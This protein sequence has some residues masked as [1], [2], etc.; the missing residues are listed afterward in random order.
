MNADPHATA[1]EP[2][3]AADPED[4][5]FML[6]ESHWEALQR[7]EL[8][9]LNDWVSQHP[10]ERDKLPHL[11]LVRRLHAALQVLREDSTLEEQA[12]PPQSDQAGSA[13][14]QFLEPGTLIDQCRI[15]SLLGYGGMGEVYLAEHTVMGNKIAV[16]VLP[17]RRVGDTEAVGRFQQEI[18]NQARMSPHPNVA[19]ALH[20]SE[21]QG[22]CY[23]VMEY[24]PGIDLHEYVRRQGPLPWRQA[25]DFVR[26][27]AVGLEYVHRH[28]IVHR[29]LKPSNLLVTP[30]GT[31]KI[32]DLGLARHRPAEVVLPDGSLTPDGAVLGT[33]DY[34]APE[35]ARSATKA[36]ARSDL[37][38][39]GCTFY[40]LLTGKAPFADRVRLDKVTAH[41]RDLPAPLCLHRSDVP[42][43]VA[44]VIDKLLAKRPEDRYASA[45]ELIEAL[46][47][48]ATAMPP[49][50]EAQQG[51]PTI[52]VTQ[53]IRVR[54]R[55]FGVLL[56][57]AAC[58]GLTVAG[59]FLWRPWAGRPPSQTPDANGTARML[60][61][62]QVQKFLL[63]VLRETPLLNS[64]RY[65]SFEL[66][67]NLFEAQFHDYVKLKAE[68]SEPAHCFLLAF[69]P[70]GKEQLCWPGDPRQP[71]ERRAQL[72]YPRWFALDDG[73]GLQ[74]FVLLASRQPLQ[75][76]ED[77]KRQRPAPVWRA[78][79]P[80]AG[81][82]WRGDG[83]LLQPLART[84]DQ[85]GHVVEL[86]E[87]AL[88]IELCEKLWQAPGI[89]A[90]AVEAFA[91]VR[92][93][94]EK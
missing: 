5:L 46:D 43:A 92:A 94:G 29:D 1:S 37:Y 34:L 75:A 82:V 6:L 16:K 26:Q 36:D 68:F 39:L 79:P 81:V 86:P 44:A 27:I 11:R 38:S 20:A 60:A 90:L 91:V 76:Y 71:P 3:G 14:R 22:R 58:A 18:R 10:E 89:E 51:V 83:K 2:D 55:R 61:P 9:D 70:D 7:G 69:N 4:G 28:N 88:L 8:A 40:Y 67:T 42:E 73:L 45:R 57:A 53:P 24:V 63:S 47:A 85:R 19:A 13:G 72:D 15:E 78:L 12:T 59:L 50:A 35:Q 30:E 33:L 54:S 62:L 48:T 21:Y 65:E 56:P 80:K 77:W 74:A 31:V 52:R 23:L 87:Q 17:A 64:K 93:D 41:A 66:G 84:G 25:T 49:Q 32:L